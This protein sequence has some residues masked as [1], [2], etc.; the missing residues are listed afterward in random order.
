MF[1]TH[2]VATLLTALLLTRAG[3]ALGTITAGFAWLVRRLTALAAGPVLR[4]APTTR[5]ALPARPGEL[6]EVLF[7]QVHTRRG[8]PLTS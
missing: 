4:P 1:A 7:R 8:P 2:A 3:A 5:S 6:L